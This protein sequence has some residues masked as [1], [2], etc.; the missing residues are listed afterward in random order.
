MKEISASELRTKGLSILNSIGPDGVVITKR[1]RPV[2]R[3]IRYHNDCH[4]LIGIFKGRI[5][6]KGDIFSTGLRWNAES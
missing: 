2:A 1:G 5:K 3:L 4:D 6:I